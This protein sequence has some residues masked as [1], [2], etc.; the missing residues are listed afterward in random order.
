M[1]IKQALKIEND[2]W[3][4]IAGVILITITIIIG[5]IPHGLALVSKVVSN[6]EQFENLQDPY[7]MFGMLDSNLNLFL[8]LLPFVFG[9]FAVFFVVKNLHQQS[10]LSLTTSRKQ[11]DWSR[12]LF[13]FVLWGS[14]TLGLVAFEYFSNPQDY[15][16][17]FKL[18]PFLIL[19]CIAIV[20][21]PLQTSLEEYLF[22]GY[23]MQGI[24]VL[25]KNRWFPLLISSILFGL[26][27]LAN[28]EIDKLGKI[29]LV[30]Y[31]GS[32]FLFGIMTLMDEGLELSLGFHAANNFILALFMTA[33]WTAFQ[34]HSVIKL[35]A[36]PNPVGIEVFFPIV[37][38]YP[39]VLYVFSKKYGWSNWKEKLFGDII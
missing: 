33:D 36:E 19:F 21:I 26:L 7:A 12:I 38:I 20:F 30:Q 14:F 27:H 34:T 23:L 17:N 18:I 4:Y 11:I 10:I 16:L 24:G 8:L 39:I 31:I 1:Y 9:L 25:V 5:S 22:R 6:P 13:S 28:P 29:I 15:I 32:G 35:I 3:L 2:W 37:V